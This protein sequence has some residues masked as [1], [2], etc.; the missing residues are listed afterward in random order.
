MELRFDQH[1]QCI[2]YL[3]MPRYG[4]FRTVLG[5]YIDGMV[6]AATIQA[7]ALMHQLS[8]EFFSLQLANSS[9]IL[10]AVGGIK[11]TSSE[12]MTI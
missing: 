8:Y 10:D 3:V 1:A 5:V 6:G 7:T 11:L 4:C 12:P 9:G 2:P